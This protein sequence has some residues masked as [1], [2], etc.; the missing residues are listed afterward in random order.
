MA[1]VQRA[2]TVKQDTT[3]PGG[4]TAGSIE[5]IEAPPG[6]NQGL[7]NQ[8]GDKGTVA[9]HLMGHGLGGEPFFDADLDIARFQMQTE[10]VT[11][12]KNQLLYFSQTR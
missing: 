5:S 6:G 7:L 8:A 1:T 4:K 3:K 10:S 12:Q 9:T 11:F 2:G